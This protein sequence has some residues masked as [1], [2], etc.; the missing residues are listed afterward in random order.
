MSK[1]LTAAERRQIDF[2][3]WRRNA[4][5]PSATRRGIAALVFADDKPALT[6]YLFDLDE[7]IIVGTILATAKDTELLK[8]ELYRE[9]ALDFPLDELDL[10]ALEQIPSLCRAVLVLPR[11]KCCGPVAVPLSGQLSGGSPK[12]QKPG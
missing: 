5:F 4:L 9:R 3:E 8:R 7:K 10:S 6:A 2:S 11:P 1:D 12:D